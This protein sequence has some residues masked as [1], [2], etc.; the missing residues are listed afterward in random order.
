MEPSDDGEIL[1]GEYQISENAA[2]GI[3]VAGGQIG[4]AIGYGSGRRYVSNAVGERGT[5]SSCEGIVDIAG[6]GFGN[7]QD[8]RGGKYRVMF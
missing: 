6:H 2:V 1:K 7:C 5:V 4:T 3:G 8:S